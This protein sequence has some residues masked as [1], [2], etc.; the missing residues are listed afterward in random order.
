MAEHKAL[1]KKD[2]ATLK[3]NWGEDVQLL[4]KLKDLRPVFLETLKESERMWDV[5]LGH[6]QV[7]KHRT[8]LFNVDA[9]SVCCDPNWVGPAARRFTL[10]DINQSISIKV[11]EPGTTERVATIVAVPKKD[12][13]LAIASIIGN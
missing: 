3:K 4:N 8:H 13:S 10:A 9:K 6:I 7:V 2:E 12:D 5:H 1:K 11:T